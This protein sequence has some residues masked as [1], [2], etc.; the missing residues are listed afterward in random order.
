MNKKYYIFL[1]ILMTNSI[2][3]SQTTWDKWDVRRPTDEALLELTAMDGTQGMRET[4]FHATEAGMEYI[5]P[6]AREVV[7]I[8]VPPGVSRVYLNTL[9]SN[10]FQNG[11]F[12]TYP[13]FNIFDHYYIGTLEDIYDELFIVSAQYSDYIFFEAQTESRWISFVRYMPEGGPNGYFAFIT[14]G[15][16]AY[17]CESTENVALYNTWI[18]AGRPVP[19]IE[20]AAPDLEGSDIND[21]D[22]LLMVNGELK[23]NY[24]N[25]FNPTTIINYEFSIMNYKTAE[26]V[27]YNAMGQNIWSSGNLPFTI[28]HSPLIFDGSKFNSGIYYYS[29]IVD[30][31][32]MDTKSMILI[33]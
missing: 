29:L 15:I 2:I 24:P 11:S 19:P 18:N 1:I 26:I 30:G 12:E 7:Q 22:E 32:K 14:N 6:G 28:H 10:T 5:L 3:I 21:N 4:L 33:K 8:L 17:V 27:V 9:Q 25:P 20:T 16:I 13:R 23:Q 31:K